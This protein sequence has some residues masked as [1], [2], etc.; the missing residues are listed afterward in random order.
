MKLLTDHQP[1]YQAGP[2]DQLS[3]ELTFNHYSKVVSS[4]DVNA[5][6]II[7]GISLECEVVT[8]AELASMIKN[9]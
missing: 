3:Y 2:A 4:T 6:Y 8:N 1:F 9:Q 5:K 7:R